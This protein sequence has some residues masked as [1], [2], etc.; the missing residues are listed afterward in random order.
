MKQQSGN[1]GDQRQIAFGRYLRELRKRVRPRLTQEQIVKEF[2]INLGEM[3]T[4]VRPVSVAVCAD[5]AKKY[6]V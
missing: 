3:E 4:G 1:F 2:H 6:G 5:L